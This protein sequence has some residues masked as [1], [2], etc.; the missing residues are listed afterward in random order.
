MTSMICSISPL[1]PLSKTYHSISRVDPI[2]KVFRE[3]AFN[4]SR[5]GVGRLYHKYYARNIDFSRT[6][7]Y[8]EILDTCCIVTVEV[9]LISLFELTLDQFKPQASYEQFNR[10]V[11]FTTSFASHF[12]NR[13]SV[14]L[15]DDTQFICYVFNIAWVYSGHTF[16]VL[17]YL[18]VTQEPC[19][20][21]YQSFLNEFSLLDHL[22]SADKILSSSELQAFTQDLAFLFQ[23]QTYD[24]SYMEACKR[25]FKTPLPDH[26]LGETNR[27]QMDIHFQTG[28]LST[29]KNLLD[30]F[31]CFKSESQPYHFISE[32]LPREWTIFQDICSKFVGR[33]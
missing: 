4:W 1:E 31:D 12:F 8:P 6:D 14:T 13:N 24:M 23:T 32:R 30:Q 7:K 5:E 11:P 18:N 9:L 15:K 21:I 33:R 10:D 20:R 29:F 16:L 28:S 22:N 3:I 26:R 25:L 27:T 2:F 19:F 17:Q